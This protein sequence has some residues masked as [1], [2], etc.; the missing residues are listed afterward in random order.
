MKAI[1]IE[2]EQSAADNLK[3][4][5]Q[6]VAPDIQNLGIDRNRIGRYCFF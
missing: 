4:L 6:S 3:F 5:L 1:I 2:D